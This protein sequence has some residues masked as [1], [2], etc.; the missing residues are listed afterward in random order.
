MCSYKVSRTF[1]KP[2]AVS[3]NS[4]LY[5]GGLG[6]T[7][8]ATFLDSSGSLRS[9]LIRRQHICCI[10]RVTSVKWSDSNLALCASL[11]SD[12]L[13]F[14]FELFQ[15][16][17][18]KTRLARGIIILV[19]ISGESPTVILFRPPIIRPARSPGRSTAGRSVSN[20]RLPNFCSREPKLNRVELHQREP[21]SQE[22][23]SRG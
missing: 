9:L 21:D 20:R 19:R 11:V 5:V 10:F 6:T 4:C 18:E 12:C 22:L 7:K 3:L 15:M 17:I 23:V 2:K 13:H 16:R 1:R 14:R 8:F